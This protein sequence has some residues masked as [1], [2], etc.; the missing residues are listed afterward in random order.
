M[1]GLTLHCLS[2][3]AVAEHMFVMT[4]QKPERNFEV[5]ES[6]FYGKIIPRARKDKIRIRGLIQPLI[7]IV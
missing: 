3:L 2:S 1:L 7:N 6:S 4:Q 5:T